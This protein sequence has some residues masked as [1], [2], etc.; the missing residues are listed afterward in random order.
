MKMLGGKEGRREGGGFTIIQLWAL[1]HVLS[2]TAPLSLC[3]RF[4]VPLSSL[5]LMEEV[6]T[7]AMKGCIHPG[8]A[9]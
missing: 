5:C 6:I 9:D 2:S 1:I 4:N 7:K 3:C 8:F